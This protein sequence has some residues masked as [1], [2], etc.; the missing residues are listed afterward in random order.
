MPQASL[1]SDDTSLAYLYGRKYPLAAMAC[2]GKQVP[3]LRDVARQTCVASAASPNVQ[4]DQSLLEKQ[5]RTRR[6][7]S[8]SQLFAFSLVYL[9]TGYYVA[10]YVHIF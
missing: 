3:D 5:T 1:V 7:F 6:L 9:G 10:G 4:Q 2:N 8:R